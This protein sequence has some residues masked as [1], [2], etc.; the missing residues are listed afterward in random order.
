MK[1]TPGSLLRGFDRLTA[2][3]FTAFGAPIL[4]GTPYSTDRFSISAK[5]G[6]VAAT[7]R[8]KISAPAYGTAP[9][10]LMTLYRR[11]KEREHVAL[12]LSEVSFSGGSGASLKGRADAQ[13]F[14]ELLSI[15]G[16]IEAERSVEAREIWQALKGLEPS[17]RYLLVVEYELM[18][19]PCVS[20]AE[21]AQ[22]FGVGCEQIRRR[23][24]KAEGRL[25][26]ALGGGSRSIAPNRHGPPTETE[27]VL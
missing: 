7:L 16:E 12:D 14:R 26:D 23:I 25:C 3:V 10:A 9:R 17:D 27:T 19:R 21:L 5:H 20:R 2:T 13:R 8:V 24:R 18:G 15:D 22:Q 4:G 11:L 6:G 1:T